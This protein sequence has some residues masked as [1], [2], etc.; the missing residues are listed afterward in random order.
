MMLKPKK[1]FLLSLI[2]LGAGIQNSFSQ[3]LWDIT[4]NS[5][6]YASVANDTSLA[7]LKKQVENKEWFVSEDALILLAYHYGSQQKEFIIE[8]LEKP[9]KDT[10]EYLY[11]D[12]YYFYNLMRGYL[13]VEEAI[14]AMDS[15]AEFAP[16]GK[17]KIRAISSLAEA[18]VYKHFEKVREAFIEG[19]SNY[20]LLLKAYRNSPYQ[21]EIGNYLEIII[22]DSTIFTALQA[23]SLYSEFDKMKTV[24]LLE[25]RFYHSEGKNRKAFYDRLGILNS[26]GQFNRTVWALENETEEHLIVQYIPAFKWIE[27]GKV[28]QSYI[29]PSFV[30]F[31]KKLFE[32][33][34]S[35]LIR[36]HIKN[37]FLKTYK[38]LPPDLSTSELS[39]LDSLITIKHQIASDT[40]KWLGDEGFVK[41]LD[42]RLQN[43]RQ[44]LDR[45]N[46]ENAARQIS[47]FIDR[48]KKVYEERQ[49]DNNSPRYVTKNGYKFL[50]YNAI[51]LL[52]RLSNE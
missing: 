39:M 43:A 28:S 10:S 46:Y 11:W 2:F 13:G 34:E 44:H 33:S 21:D 22:Q 49:I 52:E 12:K 31:L 37:G 32:N 7:N 42:N 47:N 50:F 5:K 35:E 9:P 18:G 6:N 20:F 30:L 23:A 19:K 48:V 26:E 51:Y 24:E 14:A 8:N 38:P 27:E 3:S 17:I 29:R 4:P 1:Y 40:Y 16:D 36:G 41:E 15:V 45:N 25:N